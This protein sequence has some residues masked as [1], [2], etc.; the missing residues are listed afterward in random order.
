MTHGHTRGIDGNR[1]DDGRIESDDAIADHRHVQGGGHGAWHFRRRRIG[2]QGGSRNRNSGVR[3]VKTDHQYA[4]GRNV[5]VIALRLGGVANA[6]F[7]GVRAERGRAIVGN[8]RIGSDLYRAATRHVLRRGRATAVHGE[9]E[10]EGRRL[11]RRTGRRHHVRGGARARPEHD[12]GGES[13]HRDDVL[14]MQIMVD[15][16]DIDRVG[17]L[18]HLIDNGNVNQELVRGEDGLHAIHTE[19]VLWNDDNPVDGRLGVRALEHR[20]EALHVKRGLDFGRT[21][22][23]EFVRA[24]ERRHVTRIIPGADKLQSVRPC[25]NLAQ[26][27]ASVGFRR[28]HV[29]EVMLHVD[30]PIAAEFRILNELVA[31]GLKQVNLSRVVTGGEN[32][33]SERSQS[34]FGSEGALERLIIRGRRIPVSKVQTVIKR[35]HVNL[36]LAEIIRA[37]VFRIGVIDLSERHAHGDFLPRVAIRL[38]CTLEHAQRVVPTPRVHVG[39]AD[40]VHQRRVKLVLQLSG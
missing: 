4:G 31:H 29:I 8:G 30:T 7:D 21:E 23:Y 18:G 27:V 15:R 39:A 12:G 33:G 20:G 9:L 3:L 26:H 19:L 24:G 40:T 14:H 25:A 36:P 35:I 2:I 6:I 17:L 22:Q 32:L 11:G 37:Q 16:I 34:I 13:G 1:R 38:R 10:L 5:R 28:T